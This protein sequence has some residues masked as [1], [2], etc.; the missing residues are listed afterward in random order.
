MQELG[1]TSNIDLDKEE[2][3]PDGSSCEKLSLDK[4]SGDESMDE[5]VMESRH[6]D[7]NIKPDDLG[8]KTVVT[9]EHVLE[10]VSLLDS[11]AE[12]S[13]AHTNEVVA[14]EKPPSPAEK[15]KPEG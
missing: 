14:E 9:S 15:R 11:A 12:S 5:D 4:S 3:S 13:S 2:E 8:G 1:S 7:S 10:E 6:A